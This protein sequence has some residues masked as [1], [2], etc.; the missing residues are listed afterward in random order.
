MRLHLH[1]SP[2]KLGNATY[3][4]FSLARSYRNEDGSPRK[5][6]LLPLGK[7]SPE[8]ID[9]WKLRLSIF[10]NDPKEICT[11]GQL[12]FVNSRRYLDIAFFSQLYDRFE[13][14]NVFNVVSDKVLGTAE[15]AKVL[16]LSRLLDPQAKYKTVDWLKDSYLSQLMKFDIDKYNKNKIF[17]ELENIATRRNCLQKQFLKLSKKIN[18]TEFEIY[19]F[20]GTTSFFEGTECDLGEPAYDKQVGYTNNAILICLATDRLGFP[21]AWETFSGSKKEISEFKKVAARMRDALEMRNVTFCFDRGFVSE[22]N[23]ELIEN[24]VGL[25]SKYI[26][27][28]DRN[29]IQKKFDLNHFTL[30]LR[31]KLIRRYTRE[32]IMAQAKRKRVIT[33]FGG[34]Y[35]VGEDRFYKGLGMSEGRRYVVSFNA[36]IYQAEQSKRKNKIEYVKN[37]FLLLN[38]ELHDAKG[39]RC[40]NAL[41]KRIEKILSKAFLNKIIEYKILPIASKNGTQTYKIEHTINTSEL[42][43]QEKHDGILV[44]VTNHT[45]KNKEQFTVSDFDIV[46]HYKNKFVIENAFR[47]L[48]SFADLRPFFVRLD[49]HVRAHVD[50][51]MIACFINTYLYYELKKIDVPVSV[52]YELLKNNARVSELACGAGRTVTL[53]KNLP[54]PLKNIITTLGVDEIVSKT[55]LDAFGIRQ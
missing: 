25:N 8:E 42:A 16:T 7:L 37:Q 1:S 12:A 17:R 10:N 51:C 13:F 40:D 44:Y 38:K 41:E 31:P 18:A 46:N 14:N 28:L 27:A 47:Y 33:T 48:K 52:F 53:L 55:A 24:I 34:F 4:Y 15:V 35:R 45:E 32:V 21:I 5:Q 2:K 49:D 43:E 9:Q 39:E 50:I 20:D 30:N 36:A 22:T 26:S 6:V 54:D 29:Q 19:F 3:T 11:L 23:I